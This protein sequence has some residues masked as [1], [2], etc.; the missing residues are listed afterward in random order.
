MDV[1]VNGLAVDVEGIW[2]CFTMDDRMKVWFR[3]HHEMRWKV[4]MGCK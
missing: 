3:I 2:M 1:L 4:P